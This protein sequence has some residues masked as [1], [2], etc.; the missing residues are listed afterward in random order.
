MRACFLP[1]GDWD[2]ARGSQQVGNK[3]DQML[4]LV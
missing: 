1:P 3:I 4:K 2:D